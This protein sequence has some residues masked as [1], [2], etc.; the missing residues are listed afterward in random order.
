MRDKL[1]HS[2]EYA[3]LGVFVAHASARTWPRHHVLRL[4]AFS[5]LA[6]F[7]WGVLDEIHQAFVPSRSADILDL[8]ADT[9]GALLGPVPRLLRHARRAGPTARNLE[10]ANDPSLTREPMRE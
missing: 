6:T 10:P 3:V 4:F 2:L 7:A 1:V 8:A 5:A 9:L